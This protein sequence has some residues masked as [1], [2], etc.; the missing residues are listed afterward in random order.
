MP[1]TYRQSTI[2]HYFCYLMTSLQP[3]TSPE[4]AIFVAVF[5]IGTVIILGIVGV[6][7]VHIFKR[8]KRQNENF[9]FPG[10]LK[11]RRSSFF[12]K[13]ANTWMTDVRTGKRLCDFKI[14]LF[15]AENCLHFRDNETKSNLWWIL[16][17]TWKF[18]T[19]TS[20]RNQVWACLRPIW[21]SF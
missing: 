20:H 21:K 1:M 9:R 8:Y 19:Q 17:T 13:R 11:F 15:R 5:S 6:F 3:K 16:K 12:P 18:D 7:I 10:S 14:Q 4:N 2:Y